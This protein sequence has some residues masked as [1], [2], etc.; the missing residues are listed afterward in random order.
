MKGRARARGSCGGR[1]EGGAAA[2]VPA[3]DFLY[4]EVPDQVAR[5]PLLSTFRA[6]GGRGPVRVPRCDRVRGIPGIAAVPV[7]DSVVRKPVGISSA[8]VMEW[9]GGETGYGRWAT[10]DAGPLR[11]PA[12]GDV[13]RRSPAWP[14]YSWKGDRKYRV[15]GGPPGKS[16]KDKGELGG[17]TV[18]R[19]PGITAHAIEESGKAAN[20][21]WGR[22]SRSRRP[23]R[24]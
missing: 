9:C 2:A 17:V 7:P 15:L 24:P 23:T 20:P 22:S 1:W 13:G 4:D 18:A 19:G 12:A 16:R 21:S 14:P 11:G 3:L 6:G 8:R 5:V 10:E